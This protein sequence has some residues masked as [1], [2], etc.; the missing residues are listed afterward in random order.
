MAVNELMQGGSMSA[1]ISQDMTDEQMQALLEQATNRLRQGSSLQSLEKED[2]RRYAFPR[3]EVGDLPRTYT[4]VSKKGVVQ[5][6]T[7]NRKQEKDRP[8]ANQIR[9]V[10]DPVAV[11]NR[12]AEVCSP[13]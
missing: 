9:K 8:L 11:R 12:Q 3:L 4:T 10:E 7:S 13:L 5:I 6:Q 2:E 1:E